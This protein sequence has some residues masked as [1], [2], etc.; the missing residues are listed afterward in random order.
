MCFCNRDEVM[1]GDSHLPGI[2]L[3]VAVSERQTPFLNLRNGKCDTGIVGQ[4]W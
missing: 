4:F 1:L 3:R 2:S